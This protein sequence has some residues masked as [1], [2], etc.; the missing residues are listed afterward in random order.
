MVV[1]VDITKEAKTAL[2]ELMLTGE[3]KDFS[4]AVSMALVNYGV[5]QKAV[6]HAKPLALNADKPATDSYAAPATARSDMQKSSS[7][8]EIPEL[9]YLNSTSLTGLALNDVADAP[10]A[11]VSPT[12]W[13]FGQYNKFLPVKVSCRGLLSML[14]DNSRGV[15]LAEATEKIS[16][17][18]WVFGDFLHKLDQKSG[19]PREESFSAAFPVTANNGQSSRLRFANQFIGDLRQPK[20]TGERARE[21]KFNGLP[22]ALKFVECTNGKNPL[23]NLTKAGAEFAILPNPI[24]DLGKETNP[25]RKFSD[26]EI[27]FLITH[28]KRAVPE[29]FSAFC[30]IIAGVSAGANTPDEL[31]GFLS[32]RFNLEIA[33][34]AAGENQITPS[35][36]TT[37]RT[38]AISRMADLCLIAREKNG[39]RVRYLLTPMA[40]ELLAHCRQ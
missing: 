8:D 19:R 16:T 29:E 31:D 14:R 5:I 17:E 20:Q 25:D 22:A 2:D 33:E 10:S 4:E 12:R 9:F 38:G 30:S 26:E 15:P 37:Q 32:A 39:L 7:G 6:S 28:L 21:I 40:H 11:D 35:F 23:L 1:C 24:I 3:F 27:A 34:K 13:L 18:A 36:L